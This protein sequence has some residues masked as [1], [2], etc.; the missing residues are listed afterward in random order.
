MLKKHTK[1]QTYKGSLFLQYF[2]HRVAVWYPLLAFLAKQR[3][4]S[5]NF[6]VI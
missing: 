5:C 4:I 3:K 6:F 1:L 2:S